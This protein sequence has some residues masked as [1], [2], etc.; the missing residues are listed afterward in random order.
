[1]GAAIRL[2]K[3]FVLE[4]EIFEF[5]Q[6][7]KSQPTI[8]IVF[9]PNSHFPRAVAHVEKN[10]NDPLIQHY[11][12]SGPNDLV[13]LNVDGSLL[14]HFTQQ[15]LVNTFIRINLASRKFPFPRIA[16]GFA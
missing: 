2:N 16:L 7:F 15:G 9:P 13:N 1:V 10:I 4:S 3:A 6:F 11:R 5:Q 12:L 8:T 14:P